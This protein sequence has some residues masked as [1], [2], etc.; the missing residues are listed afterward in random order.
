MLS[1]LQSS[2]AT[3]AA[4]LGEHFTHLRHVSWGGFLLLISIGGSE[5]SLRV[6][7]KLGHAD[8]VCAERIGQLGI[9]PRRMISRKHFLTLCAK[10]LGHWRGPRLVLGFSF[11]SSH[12]SWP[13]QLLS[14]P[15][16]LSANSTA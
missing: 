5:A 11:L 15:E 16:D 9:G 4:K 8:A 1:R 3:T 13:I 12:M 10:D 2:S 14:G 6:D 7:G